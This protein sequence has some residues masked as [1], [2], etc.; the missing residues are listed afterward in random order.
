MALET[1]PLPF[2]TLYAELVDRCSLAEFARDFPDD[3]SFYKRTIK[4]RDYWYGQGREGGRKWTK[5][6]GPDNEGT[7]LRIAQHGRIQHAARERRELVT[8]LIR[9]GLP[10][11]LRLAG[12]LLKALA[13]AGIFRKRAV[14]VGTVAYQTYAPMLGVRLPLAATVT[15][16]LDIAQFSQVSVAIGTE[17]RA[18]PVIDVLRSVDATFTPVPRLER[19]A[20]SF[21]FQNRSQFRV[22]F[23]APNRGPDRDKA[24]RLPA[25]GSMAL[26]LRFLDF[27]IRSEAPAVVL[28]DG[29]VLVNVPA[30][31]RYALHK[32]IVARRRTATSAKIDKDVSQAAALIEI[33]ASSRRQELGE[34]WEELRQR[35]PR[36]RRL[37]Q[38]GIEM[39]PEAAREAA[40]TVLRGV[41]L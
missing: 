38:E 36:W 35:G 33:L 11:P 4:G 12:D 6:V 19:G 23:L 7:R 32:L 17:D 28:H 34:A 41:R 29:G 26:H 27:L 9:T 10:S 14:L 16:D 24:V 5:Y 39:L 3:T 18:A 40:V 30:P 25:I 15:N 37:A 21:A 2:Q 13:Q 8:A 22:E 20:P 31:A 1:L